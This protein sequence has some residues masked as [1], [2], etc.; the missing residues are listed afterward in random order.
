MGLIAASTPFITGLPFT[1]LQGS[2]LVSSGAVGIAWP[3]ILNTKFNLTAQYPGW[4][5]MGS[6]HI[7][8][9]CVRTIVRQAELTNCAVFKATL[10]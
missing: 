5:P 7:V 2:T 4:E 8:T 10:S 6:P 9:Q 1:M 3:K